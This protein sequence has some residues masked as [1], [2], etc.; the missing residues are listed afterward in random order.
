MANKEPPYRQP[1]TVQ[2]APDAL[3]FINGSETVVDDKG[4]TYEIR[5]DITDVSVSLNIDSTPGTANFSISLPDH[6]IRRFGDFRYNSLKIMS[7]VEIYYKGRFPHDETGAYPYYPAFWGV[8][9]SIVENYSDGT[10]TITVSCADILRWWQITQISMNP[11]AFATVASYG[12][13][14]KKADVNKDVENEEDFAD[15]KQHIRKD[16]VG[17]SAFG[18]IF[19][20]DSIPTILVKISNLTTKNLQPLE[21]YLNST[22]GSAEK[23]GEEL[24]AE[25]AIGD[26]MDYWV[27]R[28]E[29]IGRSLRI[30]GLVGVK[31]NAD[32]TINKAVT[33]FELLDTQ[34][35][36]YNLNSASPPITKSTMKSQLEIANEL[37]EVVKFEFFMDVNQTIVFK[38]PLY[39]MN[40]ITNKNSVID[41]LDIMSWNFNNNESEIITRMD[42]SGSWL[43]N[44]DTS[45]EDVD[46][47]I[48]IDANLA[49]KFGIRAQTRHVKYLTTKEECLNY[50]QLELNRVN[51]LAAQGSITIVGRPE[52]RLGYPIYVPS[53]DAFYYVV[54]I[55]HSFSFGG[56]FTTTLSLRAE[57]KRLKDKNDK[58]IKNQIFRNV[59]A[60]TNVTQ[61]VE[62]GTIAE[63]D[64]DNNY[65]KRL[66]NSCMPQKAEFDIVEPNFVDS[67]DNIDTTTQ[68]DWKSF[69]D[70]KLKNSDSRHEYQ[71][72]DG[73][74][75]ELIPFYN[76][77]VD[78]YFSDESKILDEQ[79]NIEEDV[80]DTEKAQQ[81]KKLKDD[82]NN[83]QKLKPSPLQ[84]VVNPNNTALTLDNEDASML[85]L[86]DRSTRNISFKAQTVDPT[87]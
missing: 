7:E 14:I 57:R 31:Y 24:T 39:N 30:M 68:G 81:E 34:V 35:I 77:G 66:S 22:F 76:Y 13:E 55:D 38:P 2:I 4:N 52:L 27:Q 58:P 16:G 19:A 12:E 45:K 11:S 65:I 64:E 63:T 60:L 48:A 37:K 79:A 21:D 86:A 20:N 40:V 23:I 74:G 26:V 10:H 1:E 84:L 50:A 47:G 82:A 17:I 83:A 75:F 44:F 6:S 73:N 61:T 69:S 25:A 56:T 85:S 62:G 32:G 46:I 49:K 8:I 9:I 78:L 54:G 87:R 41:D 51:A 80:K 5:N 36:P 53:R 43:V 33:D 42:V 28:L 71:T 18:N 72:T 70:I 15:G 59:G 29:L 3:V 67:L